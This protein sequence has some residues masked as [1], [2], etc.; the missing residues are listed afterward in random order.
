[1]SAVA[2]PIIALAS[3]SQSGSKLEEGGDYECG[4]RQPNERYQI[5]FDV[6]RDMTRKIDIGNHERKAG[7]NNG[8]DEVMVHAIHNNTSTIRAPARVRMNA[9]PVIANTILSLNA[10]SSI[11][12]FL[13]SIIGP[14]TRKASNGPC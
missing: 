3:H 14:N 12:V 5:R 6:H 1:M 9:R 4:G 2:I 13:K 8:S 10:D 7:K 11:H